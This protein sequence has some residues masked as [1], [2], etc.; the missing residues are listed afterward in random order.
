MNQTEMFGTA[1]WIDC[2]GGTEAPIFT[3]TFLADEK[4]NAEIIICGLG[5]FELKIN[6]RKVG[7][8]I[9]A[10]GAS[11]YSKRDISKFIYPL[12]DEM[13]FRTYVMRYDV[14]D[15]LISGENTL[16][17]MLGGGY[18]H[19]E[20]YLAEGNVSYGTPKLC[21]N[22]IKSSGNVVSD[23]TTLSNKG[24][25]E[26]CNLYYG[27]F[28][29]YGSIPD[30]KDFAESREIDAPD[31][32]FY[33]NIAPTDKIIETIT[34]IKLIKD[35]NGVR[36]YD[37]G[38][39]TVGRAVLKCEK[40]GEYFSVDY[41]ESI[42]GED[43]WGIHFSRDGRYKDEYISAGGA[44]EYTT[45][46]GWQGFR[47]LRVTGNAVP[48]RIEVIHSDCKVTSSFRCDN[49]VLNWLYGTYVHTQLC[50]MHAGVPS[51]CPHRER[52]GYT[53]DGQLCCEA[54]MLMLDSRE[55]YRK[56]IY[57]IG[58]CQCRKTGHVQHTAPLMGG[59]GGPCGWGGAIIEVPYAYYKIFG[60]KDFLAEFFPKML[61]FLDYL[62]S[63]SKNGL[64]CAEE[65]GGWCLGDWLPP[66]EIQIPE[67]YV[68][69]CLYAG[70]M[71]KVIEIASVIGKESNVSYLKDKIK[72]TEESINTAYYS[73]QQ[74]AFCGD[75]NGASCLALKTGLGNENVKNKV[76]S[77]Y[78]S[79]VK[80]DTGIIATLVLTDYLFDIGEGQ[81]AYELMSNESDVSFAHMMRNGATTLWENWNGES[82][83]NHPMFGAVSKFLFTKLL[84][85]GQEDDSCGFD[86]PVICP[87]I[88]EGLNEASGY[89]TTVTGRISVEYK[90]RDNRIDF[91]VSVPED[92]EATFRYGDCE[93]K[94]IGKYECSI[95]V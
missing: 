13:S 9:L 38:Q 25:F 22:L 67:T 74:R 91:S 12:N 56:W 64:V 81:L 36:Y 14:T 4:E 61:S 34:D 28:Q 50:N 60:D 84:G 41:A 2:P 66:T 72:E 21:Y 95:E 40:G 54:A 80:Y 8:D 46:F 32:K 87:V 83:Q 49:E 52:L 23:R 42:T 93:T 94:F 65:E 47:Y 63:R 35:E 57:D 86:K 90:K 37:I 18:Y 3:K 11:T 53:G 44:K 1:K 76:I 92:T 19:Q 29:D 89:I 75:I 20:L 15:Y 79:T 68:N 88:V 82:S 10:P 62:D 69:S 48:V 70:F 24:Y 45:K 31:T 16:T 6:G 85:I 26:R 39:N 78:K 58:D 71:K 33:F 7:N 51:D 59:G 43:N 27:E 30:E 73:F 17:V 55:F 77:K 5:F